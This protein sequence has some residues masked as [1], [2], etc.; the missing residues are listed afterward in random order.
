[1]QCWFMRGASMRRKFANVIVVL[2]VLVAAAVLALHRWAA[3]PAPDAFY[4]FADA[5]TLPPRGT[6]L[7]SEP[8]TRDMPKNA[9]AY[10]ILYST[11]RTDGTIVPASALVVV[12][13]GSGAEPAKQ[14]D[15]IAWAHGT[16]GIVAGCAPT[17]FARQFHEMPDLPKVLDEGWAIVAADYV[18]LG[19]AG[20][21]AYLVGEQTALAVADA[22]RA[23]RQIESVS[24]SARYVTW[25][26]S[27]G[28]HTALWMGQRG[29]ALAPELTQLGTAALAPASD[30]TA[31]VRDSRTSHF[32]K[33]VSALAVASYAKA[34]PDMDVESY[35]KPW[36]RFLV[37]DIA[38]RCFGDKRT[39]FSLAAAF[40]LPADLFAKDPLS[41]P[42]AEHLSQNTPRGPFPL[43]V[44]VAQGTADSLVLPS[45]QATYV[46]ARCAEGA[47]IDYRSFEGLTH[48][49]LTG[50]GS[51]LIPVLL[52]WS[53][54]RF[55]GKPATPN[56]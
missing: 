9:V 17:L 8:F 56:C 43:P 48:I 44:L 36:T 55:D 18:G 45:I 6:L 15:V 38:S 25:G 37:N 30:L 42:M 2:A 34:Y 4:T 35:V 21:H 24:L 16:T 54:D 47:A 19:T 20:G 26:I 11:A 51:P 32:G 1:M 23:A 3:P 33:L 46:K 31:L 49:T 40:L 41:G 13:A 52:Q 50:A 14:H 29:A 28:G 22:L 5:G 53:R 7:R 10:R 12:P 27:Q 39:L